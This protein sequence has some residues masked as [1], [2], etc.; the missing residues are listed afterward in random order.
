MA[1][2]IP[3]APANADASAS[4]SRFTDEPLSP[5]SPA[6]THPDVLLQPSSSLAATSSATNGPRQTNHSGSRPRCDK[7]GHYVAREGSSLS[8]KKR[9]P[10]DLDAVDLK[11]RDCG[12][13]A[14]LGVV[15]HFPQHGHRGPENIV[16]D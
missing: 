8:A 12:V 10:D 3:S 11:Q 9:L 14:D 7:Q 5:N 1:T 4:P 15:V 16:L 13:A 6:L 2:L